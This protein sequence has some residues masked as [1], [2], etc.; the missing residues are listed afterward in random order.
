MLFNSF[1]VT[2]TLNSDFDR[3]DDIEAVGGSASA[4]AGSTGVISE[5]SFE[6]TAATEGV[7]LSLISPARGRKALR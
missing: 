5:E 4:S 2:V 7:I 6:I 1:G 3:T